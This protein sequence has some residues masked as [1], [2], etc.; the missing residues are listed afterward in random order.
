MGTEE[1]G[2]ELGR[3]ELGA[4]LVGCTVGLPGVIG[5]L[6]LGR[7]DDGDSVLGSALDGRDLDGELLEGESELGLV[8][9]GEAVGMAFVGVELLGEAVGL[10][11]RR[12]LNEKIQSTEVLTKRYWTSPLYDTST[13]REAEGVGKILANTKLR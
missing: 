11:S 1:L 9:L 12:L 3:E 4:W 13:T 6:L 7:L 2:I 8:L 5:L 10:F